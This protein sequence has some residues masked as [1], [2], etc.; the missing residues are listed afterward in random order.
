MIVLTVS[1]VLY[2]INTIIKL[3]EYGRLLQGGQGDSGG[4]IVGMI[5]VSS[6][7]L[8]VLIAVE[9]VFVFGLHMYTQENLYTGKCGEY[10]VIHESHK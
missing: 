4:H 7:K 2:D 5:L 9:F 3:K 6:D 1:C 10:M 8:I